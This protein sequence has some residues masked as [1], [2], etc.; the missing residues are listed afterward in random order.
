MGWAPDYSGMGTDHS[1]PS[2]P[3]PM[4]PV[5][6]FFANLIQKRISLSRCIKMLS[7]NEEIRA[8]SDLPTTWAL[9][10]CKIITLFVHYIE[11]IHISIKQGYLFIFSFYCHFLH[12]SNIFRNYLNIH[13]NLQLKRE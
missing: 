2:L 11:Y 8:L 3:M 1:A 13:G 5:Q 9:E 4:V 6:L 10:M 7:H 12:I